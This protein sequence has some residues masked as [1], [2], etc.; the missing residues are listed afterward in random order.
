[1]TKQKTITVT[2]RNSFHNTSCNIRLKPGQ[3]ELDTNP[4]LYLM[5]DP[6]LKM[7]LSRSQYYKIK[8][9]CPYEE[10]RC[11]LH[12]SKVK[13][14]EEETA[15]IYDDWVVW[16]SDNYERHGERFRRFER[17]VSVKRP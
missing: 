9:L 15:Y 5:T 2:L 16:N 8:K 6:I 4:V 17:W 3:Y 12:E 14:N 11:Q 7:A 13:I 10:C 1:M